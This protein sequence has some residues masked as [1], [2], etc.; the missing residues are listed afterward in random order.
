MHLFK[1][2]RINVDQTK[3]ITRKE[4]ENLLTSKTFL[5]LD[6]T[7]IDINK[8]FDIVD[9]DNNGR[10]SFDELDR[11]IWSRPSQSPSGARASSQ[12][13]NNNQTGSQSQLQAQP[14]VHGNKGA[15]T[16]GAAK[17]EA[18]NHQGAAP[19]AGR[20]KNMKTGR[21]TGTGNQGAGD[22]MTD[23]GRRIA[24]D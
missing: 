7:S 6:M 2:K 22:G 1:S 18:K 14:R 16:A 21:G 20:G 13:K 8:V 10:I 12:K 4:F 17:P 19:A 9:V 23:V 3:Y 24:L 15:T 11:A 5:G